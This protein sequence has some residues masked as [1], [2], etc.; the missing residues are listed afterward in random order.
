MG[1]YKPRPL[2]EISSRDLRR[3][4][5]KKWWKT[6]WPPSKKD[7][8]TVERRKTFR[9]PMQ[10]F[11][12]CVGDI[13]TCRSGWCF[14]TLLVLCFITQSWSCNSSGYSEWKEHSQVPKSR[15]TPSIGV[16][17]SK[18]N[19]TLAQS[20]MIFSWMVGLDGYTKS[21]ARSK[22]HGSKVDRVW[23]QWYMSTNTA[24]GW[25]L[26]GPSWYGS[27]RD[28]DQGVHLIGSERYASII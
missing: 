12:P 27:K 5:H 26:V 11:L 19:Q 1:C 9:S 4:V 25:A 10:L 18:L 2:I 20:K 14:V 24:N 7:S 17:T 3:R 15:T 22:W 8:G 6:Y 23:N 13:A 21:R 28:A 16:R